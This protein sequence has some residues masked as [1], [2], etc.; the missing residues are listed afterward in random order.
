MEIGQPEGVTAADGTGQVGQ[1]RIKFPDN[2]PVDNNCPFALNFS[3]TTSAQVPFGQ[4][5]AEVA[6]VAGQ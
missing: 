4:S 5:S 6:P 3:L 1:L 2:A